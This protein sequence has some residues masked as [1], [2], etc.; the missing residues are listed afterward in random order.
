TVQKLLICL[1][2]ICA[3]CQYNV[4]DDSLSTD[5][6]LELETINTEID[7]L[8]RKLSIQANKKDALRLIYH[9]YRYAGLSGDFDDYKKTEVTLQN[10][11]NQ[12]GSSQQLLLFRANLN[13]KLH[14]LSK[15]KADLIRIAR[16]NNDIQVE[17]LKADIA[18][19]QG[20][21]ELAGQAYVAL[22][23]ESPSLDNLARLAYFKM[24]TGEA[25]KADQLYEQA[26]NTLSVKQMRHYAWLELQR[27]IID[28]EH[29][30]YQQA[31]DHYQRAEQ[32]YSGYWL[33]REH[34]AEV[35]AL[36]DRQDEAVALYKKIIEQTRN[37]E[38]ISA[39]A[40]LYQAENNPEADKLYA[41]A[42]TLFDK[43]YQL[44]PEAAVGHFV[45][46]LLKRKQI[47][48]KTLLYAI[49]NYE[50]RANAQSRYLLAKAYQKEGN[51]T[52]AIELIQGVLRTP[53]RSSDIENLMMELEM[54]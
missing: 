21:Y 53:W 3:G 30:R 27:G 34:I 35:Y 37:P 48:P 41:Q 9:L 46:S 33:I 49:R 39:L 31:L 17:V 19:Q 45:E 24:H 52:K 8:N 36:L 51:K 44:F 6:K 14:R 5:Y 43:Q 38:F 12:Y 54:E 15:A 7:S 25:E 29:N 13:F 28:L 26:Q 4:L 47:N 42:D 23:A 18:L 20:Q 10:T 32:A 11:L 22:S 40:E 1:L 50:W 2:V 16:N